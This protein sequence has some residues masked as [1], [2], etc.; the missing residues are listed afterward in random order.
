MRTN[1]M[2]PFLLG[3]ALAVNVVV[4]VDAL[5]ASGLIPRAE[6]QEGDPAPATASGASDLPAEDGPPTVAPEEIFD[7]L[8]EQ[9]RVRDRALDDREAAL[10]E[11][12]RQLEVIRQQLEAEA[13]RLVDQRAALEAEKKELESSGSPSFESLVKAYGQMDPD[14]AAG[15]LEELYG[16]R[17]DVVIDVV[18]AL[19]PRQA[20]AVLDALASRNPKV[21]ASL[22]KQIWERS[23]RAR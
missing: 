19:K 17:Q 8:V 12:E 7:K 4:M 10:I 22:S 15:A 3:L 20:G 5:T 16:Q 18:L 6:A 2:L 14:N 9:V 1:R 11:Q 21:A 23:P 13:A